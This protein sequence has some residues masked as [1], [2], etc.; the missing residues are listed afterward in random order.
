MTFT[1][2]LIVKVPKDL[3]QFVGISLIEGQCIGPKIGLPYALNQFQI[4]TKGLM[5]GIP[6][7][8]CQ[9][10]FLSLPLWD[11]LPKTICFSFPFWRSVSFSPGRK[12]Y[13]CG[14]A[15]VAG[16]GNGIL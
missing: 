12:H 1:M 7:V 16:G 14:S 2:W 11:W 10:I 6:Q 15:G 5:V 4:L 9:R 13:S 8:C 3:C